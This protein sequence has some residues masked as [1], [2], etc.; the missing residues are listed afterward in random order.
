MGGDIHSISAEIGGLKTAV[1]TLKEQYSE[2]KQAAIEARDEDRDVRRQRHAEI[3]DLIKGCHSR[4]DEQ[5]KEIAT[6][7]KY[8]DRQ[9]TVFRAAGGSVT[10]ASIL[11]GIWQAMKS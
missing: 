1:Q 6:H 4:M 3:C 9:K 10:L 7:S 8:I 2:G 5:S 11:A